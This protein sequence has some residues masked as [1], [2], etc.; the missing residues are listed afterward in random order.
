M[1]E[2]LVYP[3][4]AVQVR[5]YRVDGNLHRTR[6]YGSWRGLVDDWSQRWSIDMRRTVWVRAQKPNGASA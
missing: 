4:G 5:D 3:S 2:I 6:D 1:M